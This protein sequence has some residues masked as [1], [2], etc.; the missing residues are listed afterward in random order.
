MNTEIKFRDV[1]AS[2]IQ[3]MITFTTQGSIEE[4]TNPS[5]VQSENRIPR[6]SRY[7]E[8]I[9]LTYSSFSLENSKDSLGLDFKK[10]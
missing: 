10:M 9:H 5:R 6:V 8:N 4:N 1:S 2:Y 3:P 7:I